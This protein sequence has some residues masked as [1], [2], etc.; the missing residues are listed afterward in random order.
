M[1]T[2]RGEGGGGGMMPVQLSL[3]ACLRRFVDPEP[4][5]VHD[6]WICSRYGAVVEYIDDNPQ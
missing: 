5:G 2:I 4:V 1:A 6:T 3:E